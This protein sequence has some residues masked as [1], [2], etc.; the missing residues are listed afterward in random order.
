MIQSHARI[1]GGLG[2]FKPFPQLEPVPIERVRLKKGSLQHEILKFLS[3]A[4]ARNLTKTV[5]CRRCARKKGRFFYFL[6]FNTHYALIHAR[7][8][9]GLTIMC[10]NKS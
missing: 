2:N 7:T 8:F 1:D 9:L 5:F 4:H 6:H 3:N 10:T